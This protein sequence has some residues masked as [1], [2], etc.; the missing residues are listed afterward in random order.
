MKNDDDGNCTDPSLSH[1][2]LGIEKQGAYAQE[3]EEAAISLFDIDPIQSSKNI[4]DRRLTRRENALKMLY[5]SG[6]EDPV[7]ANSGP[8]EAMLP[9][10][11][12]V[13]P[14]APPLTLDFLLHRKVMVYW[15]EV[16]ATGWFWGTV[17]GTTKRTGFNFNVKYDKSNT[18]NIDVDGIKAAALFMEGIDAYG[19][20]WVLLSRIGDSDTRPSTRMSGGMEMEMEMESSRP[21]TAF[22]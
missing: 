4:I 12:F 18:A 13:E 6:Q 3:Q 20:G 1:L 8:P 9:T 17:C 22:L 14:L 19:K 15:R 10:G 11:Y 16:K 21:S 7:L 5:S 2:M